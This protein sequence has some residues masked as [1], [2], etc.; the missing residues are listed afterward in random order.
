LL[1]GE[2]ALGVGSVVLSSEQP[3]IKTN[4]TINDASRIFNFFIS[5]FLIV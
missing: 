2:E 3:K 1:N 4:V 5:Y